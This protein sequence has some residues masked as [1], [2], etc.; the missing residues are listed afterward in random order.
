[1]RF[2]KNIKT[3]LSLQKNQTSL[4]KPDFFN[5]KLDEFHSE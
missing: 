2:Q 3:S 4:S 1:M 5:F